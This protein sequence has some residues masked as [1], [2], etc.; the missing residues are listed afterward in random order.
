ME[1]QLKWAGNAAF[2]GRASSGHTIVMDGP[3]EGGGR[4]LGPRPMEML[5]LG[6]GACS[7]YDVVSILKKSRQEITDCEIKITS[8]RADSD[9]KVFTDI[10]LHFIVS[11]HNLKEKQVER[12]IKLSA[13]KYCSASIMLGATA[14]ITHDFEIINVD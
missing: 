5:I 10:Q 1:T 14:N 3:A 4:N 11:G 8:Q 7:T 6:M 12:A 13:E 2:I 9:P